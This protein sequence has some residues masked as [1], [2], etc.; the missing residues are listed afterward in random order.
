MEAYVFSIMISNTDDHLRNHGFLYER[1]KGW[2]LSPVYDI[3]PTPLEVKPHI[4]TTAINFDDNDASLEIA[5]SVI[6]DFSLS[7]DA[8]HKIIREVREAVKQWREVATTLG[9]TKRECDRMSS[10]FCYET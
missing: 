7:L 3:N 4:L 6:Q 1:Y 5:L 9:L 10:A 2:R 8:A